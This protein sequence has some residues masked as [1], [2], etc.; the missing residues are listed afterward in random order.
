MPLDEVPSQAAVSPER[1]FQIHQ[2]TRPDAAKGSHPQGLGTQLRADLA[3]AD[4][5]ERE[6]DTVDRQAI[7]FRHLA[8]SVASSRNRAPAGVGLSSRTLPTASINPVNIAFNQR[9]GAERRTRTFSKDAVD[10]G[11]CGSH[12][13]P[14]APSVVGAR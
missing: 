1:P 11:T 4:G 9:I 7:A 13:T 8:A 5:N 3:L 12:G 2:G 14:S 6:A 10:S